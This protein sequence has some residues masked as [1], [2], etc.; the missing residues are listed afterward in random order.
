[1][2]YLGRNFLLVVFITALLCGCGKE[3][4]P[5]ETEP[6]YL[7]ETQVTFSEYGDNIVLT[8]GDGS[9]F[10]EYDS[11]SAIIYP[12]KEDI[13][14]VVELYYTQGNSLNDFVKGYYAGVE[15]D[16]KS[17]LKDGGF[18]ADGKFYYIKKTETNTYFIIT[19]S[20]VYEAYCRELLDSML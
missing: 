13:T 12:N 11:I 8:L 17:E 9:A 7:P 16:N 1:M 10:K 2:W 15:S 14:Q 3:E 4:V 6:P 19:G 5:V 20:E 18:T